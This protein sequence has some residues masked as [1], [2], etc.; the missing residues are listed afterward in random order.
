MT[1]CPTVASSWVAVAADEQ[2]PLDSRPGEQGNERVTFR[3]CW[4]DSPV[5]AAHQLQHKIPEPLWRTAGLE[6]ERYSYGTDSLPESASF[7]ELTIQSDKPIVMVGAMRPATSL[8]ADGPINLLC[9][10]NLAASPKGRRRGVMI[11]SNDRIWAPWYT[12]K[13]HCNSVD[14]FEAREQGALGCFVSAQPMFY[15]EPSRPE[16][17]A[18]FDVSG[19][20][21]DKGLPDFEILF[22]R[23]DMDSSLFNAA[24]ARGSKSVVLAGMGAGC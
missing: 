11:V 22:G 8:S 14:A 6:V 20:E 15:W 5:W 9:A 4:N 19:L 17:H 21:A 7:L 1:I 16:G 12:T 23:M 10:V 18:H 13:S 24:V 2:P 3:A